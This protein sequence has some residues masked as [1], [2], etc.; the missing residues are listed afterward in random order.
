M[1]FAG[2]LY[3][4][5]PKTQ[6]SS[7]GTETGS[8]P[9]SGSEATSWGYFSGKK[10]GELLF[11]D[12]GEHPESCILVHDRVRKNPV[13]PFVQ[14]EIYQRGE[15]CWLIIFCSQGRRISTTFGSLIS[16]DLAESGVSIF[17]LWQMCLIADS[18]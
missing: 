18:S 14:N 15:K 11:L 9:D 5:V 6:G 13:W 8:D 1:N 12:P 17:V 16:P 4:P 7:S 10:N 3:I 2:I